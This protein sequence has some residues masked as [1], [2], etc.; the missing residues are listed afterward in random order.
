MYAGKADSLASDFREEDPIFATSVASGITA[1]DTA[2]WNSLS[3]KQKY[4]I[5]DILEGG[6]VFYVE[7]DG[8]HG[9]VAALT[10]LADEAN[11]GI[12]DLATG[13]VSQYDGKENT[14]KIVS[15]GGAGDYAAYHCDT[16]TLNSYEDWYLPSAD[17]MYLLLRNRYLINQ[18]LEEDG[19]DKT[20]GLKEEAYWTS[21]E[22]ESS[23]AYIFLNGNLDTALK[24]QAAYVR[25]IRVF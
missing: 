1:E 15:A 14:Q 20:S 24:E 18:I 8:K 11:W 16:L 10:D 25:P 4:Q 2:R 19:D 23:E 22:R 17:E 6:I 7:P 9:L 5:G 12:S 13:A 3:K 21:S